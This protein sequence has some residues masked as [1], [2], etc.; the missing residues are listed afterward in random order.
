MKLRVAQKVWEGCYDE[1]MQSL[2]TW[3]FI[4][5]WRKRTIEAAARRVE[6]LIARYSRSVAGHT[7]GD[8]R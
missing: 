5:R 2:S 8:V 7:G 6:K 4:P 1:A 3:R